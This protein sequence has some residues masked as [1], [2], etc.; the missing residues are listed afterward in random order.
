[1]AVELRIT[2]LDGAPKHTW[3]LSDP[4]DIIGATVGGHR[5]GWFVIQELPFLAIDT[6]SLLS[7]STKPAA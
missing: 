7:V 3:T 5:Y 2:D 6:V 1:L 4:T